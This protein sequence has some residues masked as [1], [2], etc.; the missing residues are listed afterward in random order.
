MSRLTEN[1]VFSGT[2]YITTPNLFQ[3]INIIKTFLS[4]RLLKT[5][6]HEQCHTGIRT[7]YHT[8]SQYSYI[9]FLE[10]GCPFLYMTGPNVNGLNTSKSK[11]KLLQDNFFQNMIL[12]SLIEP[13]WIP[14]DQ[15]F[16]RRMP[17]LIMWML[18]LS[19]N[20]L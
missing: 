5:K 18:M 4:F 17:N 15:S 11:Y 16:H 8:F 7:T 13:L 20:L 3:S 12:P 1:E 14:K 9:L 19:P 10:N 2:H 6:Q